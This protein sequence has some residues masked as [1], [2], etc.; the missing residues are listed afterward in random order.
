MQL[1]LA[2]STEASEGRLWYTEICAQNPGLRS[3]APDICVAGQ[4]VP[5]QMT[6][7]QHAPLRNIPEQNIPEQNF[8]RQD[9]PK[10]NVQQLYVREQNFMEQNVPDQG[11]LEC[12][13]SSILQDLKR[14]ERFDGQHAI[15]QNPLYMNATFQSEQFSACANPSS[16]AQLSLLRVLLS[17]S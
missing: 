11:L 15:Q 5:G 16:G 7:D 13:S 8:P 10:Q 4:N 9:V 6:P 17:R 14:S 2:P 12:P 3:N 1:Q